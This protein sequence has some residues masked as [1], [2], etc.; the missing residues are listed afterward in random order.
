MS[1]KICTDELLLTLY[2]E[3]KNLHKVADVLSTYP[4]TILRRLKTLGIKIYKNKSGSDHPNWRGGKILNKGNGY[5]GI[6][7]PTHERADSGGYVYEHTLNFENKFGFLP[8]KNEVLHHIDLD[9]HNNNDDNL[10]LCNNRKHLQIH[11]QIEKLI[12]PLMDKGIV[13]FE[14]GEYLIAS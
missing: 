12:K 6:H 1:H 10:Y 9:K 13:K 8:G 14:N 2:E 4:T 11:R 5:V 7:N 3:H